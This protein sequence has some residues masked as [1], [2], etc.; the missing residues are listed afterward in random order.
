MRVSQDRTSGTH[1]YTPTMQFPVP[2]KATNS[3]AFT[4][5]HT[6]SLTLSSFLAQNSPSKVAD[7]IIEKRESGRDRTPASYEVGPSQPALYSSL[8]NL[9][10]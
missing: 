8:I 7:K 5:T 2:V 9:T 3:L 6:P 4:L 10:S 1:N